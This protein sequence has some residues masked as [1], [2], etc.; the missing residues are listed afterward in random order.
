M[1]ERALIITVLAVIIFSVIT[2][3]GFS[4][5][6]VVSFEKVEKAISKLTVQSR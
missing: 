1:T 6:T 4:K 5:L 3:T 2:G